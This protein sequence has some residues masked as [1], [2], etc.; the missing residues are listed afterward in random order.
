MNNR[1]IKFRAWDRAKNGWVYFSIDTLLHREGPMF[2]EDLDNICEFTGLKDKNGK[3]IYEGDILK[4]QNQRGEEE[5]NEAGNIVYLFRSAKVVFHVD[6]W[7]CELADGKHWDN[8][9]SYEDWSD[10]VPWRETEVIGN[11]YKNPEL[12]TAYFI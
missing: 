1:E 10:D 4:I 9:F 6:A 7:K 2:P 12:L 3:E 8:G 11:I 5:L